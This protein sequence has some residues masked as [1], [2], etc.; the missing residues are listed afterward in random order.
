MRRLHELPESERLS[1]HSVLSGMLISVSG[2]HQCSAMIEMAWALV[3]GKLVSTRF[4][5]TL[6]LVTYW[7]AEILLNYKQVTGLIRR[8]LEVVFNRSDGLPA[9]VL[10]SVSAIRIEDLS[11]EVDIYDTYI[12]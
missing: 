6:T 1:I 9:T 12:T 7:V 2:V 11:R 3:N 4:Q 10:K 8:E 5:H